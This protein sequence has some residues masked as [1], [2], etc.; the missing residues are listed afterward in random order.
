[1]P[2]A[3]FPGTRNWGYDGVHPYAVQNSYG[4]PHGL[5]EFVDAAHSVGLGVVLDV[6]YNH[7]GPEGNYLARFGPYFTSRYHT[8]WGDAINYDGADSESVRRFF[9]D[10][11]CQW[12]RDFHLDGLRLDAVQAIFDLSAQ[13]FLAEL[14]AAVE[15]TGAECGRTVVVTAES[16]QNDVRLVRSQAAGG[17]GHDALWNDDFHHAVHSALTGE[18]H[19]YY[20]DFGGV[21]PVVKVLNDV[22]VNDGDYSPY[23]RRRHGNRVGDQS[24]EQF[25]VSIQN[26]DQIGNRAGGERLVA[27]TSPEAVRGAAA[28]LLL[29][30]FTPLLFMGEEYGETRPFPFFSSFED[31]GLIEAVRCGRRTEFAASYDAKCEALDPQSPETF[32]A[33]VVSWDWQDDATRAGMRNLYR[34]LLAARRTWPALVDRRR[35]TAELDAD[36]SRLLVVR[37]GEAPGV[38]AWWNATPQG[39]PFAVAL[40]DGMRLVLSTAE[41]RFGGRRKSLDGVAELQPY[42][43]V[44]AGGPECRTS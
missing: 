29:S 5:Q 14:Q 7:L 40:P 37:R 36:D 4:G 6:V 25:I 15:R 2:V 3:Q 19:C 43:L 41:Q 1:M 35:T 18:T 21:A 26:H 38:T 39:V 42:E 13:P 33:A 17:I 24:R 8:P 30:P 16:N 12:I 27:L 22:F 31:H 11:A 32:A 20:A 34:T 23:R 10:N 28:L 9:I 44:I